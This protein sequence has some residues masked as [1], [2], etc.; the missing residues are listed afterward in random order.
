MCLD[1]VS[2]AVISVAATGMQVYGQIQAGNAAAEAGKYNAGVLRNQSRQELTAANMTAMDIRNEGAKKGGMIRSQQAANGVD[3][4]SGSA[5][6]VGAADAQAY[7]ED[8][9]RALYGGQIKSWALKSEANMEIYEGKV[10]KQQA[11][12][13]AAGTLLGAAAKANF[14]STPKVA[15]GPSGTS[16]SSSVGQP[17][18]MGRIT[19][20]E[21]G[22]Y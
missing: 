14:S 2:M 11:Y 12:I 20:F 17:G 15:P 8:A 1:P 13:Q 21:S 19:P 9:L 22:R 18:I 7:E 3:I 10:K 16:F 4:A 5:A 6:D